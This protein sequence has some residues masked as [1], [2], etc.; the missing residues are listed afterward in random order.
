MARIFF[1]HPN[2]Q[3]ATGNGEIL[4]QRYYNFQRIYTCIQFRKQKKKI[5]PTL[6]LENDLESGCLERSGSFYLTFN[7]MLVFC[8]SPVGLQ[9]K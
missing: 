2:L 5:K 7:K 6:S 8:R 9:T 1:S 3:D 4:I